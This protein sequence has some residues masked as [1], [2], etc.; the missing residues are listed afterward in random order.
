MER[1]KRALKIM[2]TSFEVDPLFLLWVIACGGVAALRAEEK[3]WYA[4][5]LVD[6]AADLHLVSWD[7]IRRCL[8]DFIAVHEACK[9]RFRSLWDE[10]MIR[11]GGAELRVC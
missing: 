10:V 7:E 3:T 8:V 9:S 1:L 4:T 6:V 5:R 11:D 2:T